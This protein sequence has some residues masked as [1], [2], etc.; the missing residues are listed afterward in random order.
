MSDRV[1][2]LAE[3]AR[4]VGCSVPSLYQLLARTSD[5]L[6]L[7]KAPHER[8]PW[9][10]RAQ[11]VAFR[12]R[13]ANPNDPAIEVVRGWLA[14]AKTV[15]VSVTSAKELAVRP[16]D[17]LPVFRQ[18]V[19]VRA[20]RCALLDWFDAQQRQHVLRSGE[21]KMRSEA[22]PEKATRNRARRTAQ[23]REPA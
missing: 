11:L 22:E 6:R 5:P 8:K 1:Q 18:G 9:Q 17:P 10:S 2:G 15:R 16:V 19:G 3:I 14:I 12:R 7:L 20:F 4:V 23:K 21:S 13:W